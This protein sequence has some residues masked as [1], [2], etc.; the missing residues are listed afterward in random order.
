MQEMFQS[1][2]DDEELFTKGY[3]VLRSVV[4]PADA[5]AHL[6]DEGYRGG[7]IHNEEYRRFRFRRLNNQSDAWSPHA[8]VVFDKIW[9]EMEGALRNNYFLEG[10]ECYFAA[11][12]LLASTPPFRKRKLEPGVQP[13]HKDIVPSPV[14]PIEEDFMPCS[15][16]F[17]LQDDT[18]VNVA[19]GIFGLKNLPYAPYT[20]QTLMLNA[21]DILIFRSDLIHAGAKIPVR[22]V[23][24]HFY[25]YKSALHYQR[26]REA[27]SNFY[28][29]GPNG[30]ET[31][32]PSEP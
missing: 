13:W 22:N 25:V 9:E 30:E 32:R 5:A 2:N 17:A 29:V 27:Q 16:I 23:R 8:A 26:V 10:L 19:E 3:V 7:K 4:E 6:F 28:N 18:P 21:G 31:E 1:R 14:M 20:G 12:G 11:P 15:G 24:V